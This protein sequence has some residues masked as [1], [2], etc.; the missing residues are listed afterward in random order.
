M[1]RALAKTLHH[2]AA[3]DAPAERTHHFPEHHS[4]SIDLVP[5]FLIPGEQL[6][7]RAK[8]ADRLVDLA[9]AP[10]VDADPAEIFHRIADMREL[11]VQHRAHAVRADDEVAVAEIAMYQRHLL[12]RA[13][14]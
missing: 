7:S 12:R 6:F 2:T 8:A 13:G 3:H 1:I 11:P 9:E 10:G 14:I 4:V 5:G